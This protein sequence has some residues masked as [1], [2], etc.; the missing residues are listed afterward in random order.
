MSESPR[1]S[2]KLL[3]SQEQLCSVEYICYKHCRNRK[4]SEN[5]QDV[6]W[7]YGLDRSGSGLRQVAESCECG[8]EHSDSIKCGEFLD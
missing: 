4:I 8:N 5:I 2:E 3:A 7:G 6:R 1:V